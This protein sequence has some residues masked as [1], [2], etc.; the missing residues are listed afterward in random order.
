MDVF[1]AL[2]ASDPR[3]EGS[4]WETVNDAGAVLTIFNMPAIRECLSSEDLAQGCPV[5]S[6]EELEERAMA[7]LRT[8]FAP[9]V[10]LHCARQKRRANLKHIVHTERVAARR[11]TVAGRGVVDHRKG[12]V[13][14][15]LHHGKDAVGL[16]HRLQ[17]VCSPN[18]LIVTPG[19]RTEDTRD[20]RDM[21][22]HTGHR[23]SAS[24]RGSSTP[25]LERGGYHLI[26]RLSNVP[27][28]PSHPM[29]STS[30][31]PDRVTINVLE[32][33]SPRALR[34]TRP[35]P[36]ASGPPPKPQ[37]GSRGV[38]AGAGG[39]SD[40]SVMAKGPPEKTSQT[41]ADQACSP[42]HDV[43]AKRNGAKTLPHRAAHAPVNRIA[44]FHSEV[45]EAA[46]GVQPRKRKTPCPTYPQGVYAFGLHPPPYGT[47]AG[48]G[49]GDGYRIP[50]D[51]SCRVPPRPPSSQPPGAPRPGT[52]RRPPRPAVVG[53]FAKGRMRWMV[54]TRRNI[55]SCPPERPASAPPSRRTTLTPRRWHRRRSSATVPT[56]SDPEWEVGSEETMPRSRSSLGDLQYIPGVGVLDVS[57]PSAW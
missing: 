22:H 10:R 7:K 28:P 50:R 32:G 56:V 49:G 19:R 37:R 47:V 3:A 24:S 12:G 31:T 40:G 35:T 54:T 16:S 42:F 34:T 29:R 41:Q 9:R 11:R 6:E 44:A 23:C 30:V 8:L 2:L 25:L 20:L 26:T 51:K 21:Q 5:V 18:P 33:C 43:P 52:V 55:P 36:R 39:S 17:Q 45:R 27:S 14:I 1:S 15:P 48:G 53:R 46:E 13:A 4:L 38:S 57:E